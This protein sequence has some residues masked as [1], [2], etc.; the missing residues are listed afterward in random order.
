MAPIMKHAGIAGIL[1]GIFLLG[2]FVFFMLSGYS[3]STFTNPEAAIAF[4][5]ESE[6]PLRLAV[7]FGAFGVVAR[8]IYVAGLAARLQEKSPTAA[9]ATNYFGI[10]GGIGHGLVA[11]SFYVGIPMILALAASQP[12]IAANA[13]GAFTAITSGFQNLGNFL[14][15][16]MALVVGI[17]ILTSHLLPRGLGYVATAGGTITLLVVWTTSTPLAGIGYALFMPSML[18]AVVF[19]IWGGIALLKDKSA[20]S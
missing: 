14:L 8:I 3:P 12:S 10:L 15:G 4:L 7:V 16:L 18:L 2:E 6:L 17:T 5:R 13:W 11:L 19:D 9:V 20:S 1:T